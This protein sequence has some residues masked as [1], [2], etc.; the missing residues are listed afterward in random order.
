GADAEAGRQCRLGL[1]VDL[2]EAH[3]GVT[4][5]RGL[6]DR[7]EGAAGRAPVG[8]EVDEDNAPGVQGRVE[9]VLGELDDV[10]PGIVT[11]SPPSGEDAMTPGP[12]RAAAPLAGV[13]RINASRDRSGIRAT[14]RRRR[15]AAAGRTRR[16]PAGWGGRGSGSRT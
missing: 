15:S 8:P 14:A 16:A 7:A 11:A 3:V 1:G 9:V 10:H 6:E 4:R 2:P 12:P 13:H 5:G